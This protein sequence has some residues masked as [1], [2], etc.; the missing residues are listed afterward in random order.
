MHQNYARVIGICLLLAFFSLKAVSMEGYSI[1]PYPQSVVYKTGTLTLGKS[2]KV[3]YPKQLR[4]EVGFLKEYLSDEF[5]VKVKLLSSKEKGD[6]LLN[7][8]PQQTKLKENGYTLDVSADGIK[9]TAA[10]ANGIFNGIQ[11]LRQIIIRCENTLTVQQGTITDYP[12]FSW[13]AFMLDEGRHFKGKQEV[14]RVLDQMALLKMNV[15]HWHLTDDQGWRIEIKKYPRLT[16]IGGYRDSTEIKHFGSNEYDGLPHS[17]YYTQKDIKEII[18]YATRR[19][20]QVIPEIEMPGH[21]SAA[22]AAYPWLG[23]TNKQ[24]KVPCKFGVQYDIFN[25]TDPKVLRFFE[26]V[27]DEVIALFPAPI[28]HIGG[29]EVRPN[30]WNESPEVKAYMAKHNLKSPAE[31]QVFFTNNISNLLA[32]KGKRMMGWNEITGDRLHDYQNKDE[33]EMKQKLSKNTIVQFWQGAPGLITS[34][35]KS[36]YEVVNSYHS[37]T[38]L[39]YASI[40]LSKAYAFNPIP[41]ELPAE[42]QG[43]V[44]GLGCQMWSEFVPT[45]ENMNTKVY[46]RLAAYAECGWTVN[47]NKN[48]DR[49]LKCLSPILDRWKKAGIEI[50]KL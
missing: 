19:H 23:V 14:K 47:E 5:G 30:H 20:I 43:K 18:A 8:D 44:L 1:V 13:R 7:L 37:S 39:D 40:T 4:S 32:T 42:L 29:D 41:K 50:G 17:G 24:I 46:P 36:G 33:G 6:I 34:T 38:Y 11:T 9:L 28:I 16:E 27:I 3:T 12:A 25:V 22:I 31:L 48:Y 49:F 2:V 45:A 26:E 15:F 21:A 10:S 35:I